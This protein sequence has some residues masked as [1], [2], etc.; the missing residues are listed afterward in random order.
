MATTQNNGISA[1][2]ISH[3]ILFTSHI[4]SISIFVSVYK[5]RNWDTKFSQVYV[6]KYPV[7]SAFKASTWKHSYLSL[8]WLVI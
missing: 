4:D 1:K 5:Q 6:M 8:L 7:L 3:I 2:Y